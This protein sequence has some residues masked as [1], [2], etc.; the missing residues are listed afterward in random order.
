MACCALCERASSINGPIAYDKSHRDIN[1]P[2]MP[3]P[4]QMAKSFAQ[5][6]EQSQRLVN[7]YLERQREGKIPAIS[8]DL[9]LS[10]AFVDLAVSLMTNP[11]KLAEVQMQMWTDHMRLMAKHDAA[12]SR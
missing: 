1:Q 11:W 10:H 5:I 7:G 12:L 6:A 8:D 3:D 4:Q 2:A 9:G